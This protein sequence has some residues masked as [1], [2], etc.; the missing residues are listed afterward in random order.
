MR[1][2]SLNILDI[3][4][5]SVKAN[6]GKIYISISAQNG[7]LTISVKDNGSG[8]PLD[9]LKNV[10]DPFT[11]TRTTRKVGMGIPLFK[12]AAESAGGDFKIT[13]KLYEGTQTTATFKIDHIDRMPLGNVGETIS[14]LILTNPEKDFFL[15]YEV[16]DRLYEFNTVEIK[17]VL[18]N[19]PID[20]P[21]IIAYIKETINENIKEV[22]GGISL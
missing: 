15:D 16:E 10:E 22:N 11:T 2:L 6:A 13:S 20:S 19:V 21:E 7:L 18:E 8:M 1:E 3:A 12:M 14:S 9:F 17:E 4:Q 5:N